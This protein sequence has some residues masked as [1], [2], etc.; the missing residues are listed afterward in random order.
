[1]QAQR[2][3]VW[4]GFQ[5]FDG[6]EITFGKVGVSPQESF[7]PVQIGIRE[8]ELPSHCQRT[9][10]VLRLVAFESVL[11]VGVTIFAMSYRARSC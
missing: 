3:M 8:D 9:L 4:I 1:M 7:C 6:L 11:A 10:P 5:K 2:A